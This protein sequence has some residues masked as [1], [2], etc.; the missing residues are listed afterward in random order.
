METVSRQHRPF[1]LTLLVVALSLGLTLATPHGAP[2]AEAAGS[3]MDQGNCVMGYN[4][5]DP[6]AGYLY[7]SSEAFDQCVDVHVQILNQGTIQRYGWGVGFEGSYCNGWQSWGSNWGY[8]FT[9]AS[10]NV[11]ASQW[12]HP[13]SNHYAEDPWGWTY[14]QGA[15]HFRCGHI[16]CTL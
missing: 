3:N 5:A 14:S 6:A 12:Q 16:G 10:A 2:K 7:A 13:C 4:Y 9:S 15:L 11:D 8:G 1:L